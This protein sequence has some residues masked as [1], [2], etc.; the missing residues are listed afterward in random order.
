MVELSEPTVGAFVGEA[1]VVGA[2]GAAAVF[3]SGV[4]G[5]AEA[6]LVSEAE[7]VG[8]AAEVFAMEGSVA[9]GVPLA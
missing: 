7:V 8:V 5:V 4:G 3:G 6:I 2:V 1:E 9:E